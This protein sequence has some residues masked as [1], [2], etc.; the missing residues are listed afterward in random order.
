MKARDF[1]VI[2]NEMRKLKETNAHKELELQ[3]VRRWK[4]NQIFSIVRISEHNKQWCVFFFVDERKNG[5]E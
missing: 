4:T 3:T 5:N 2:Q 1:N